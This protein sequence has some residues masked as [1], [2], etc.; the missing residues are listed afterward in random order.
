MAHTG[1]TEPR[2]ARAWFAR[3][4]GVHPTTVS[5]W[6]AGVLPFTGPPAAVLELLEQS[7]P[8]Q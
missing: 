2:G 8:N 7:A 6:L 4:A 3:L 5:R 1:A